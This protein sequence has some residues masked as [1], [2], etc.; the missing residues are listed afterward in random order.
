MTNGHYK[1]TIMNTLKKQKPGQLRAIFILNLLLVIICF[2]FYYFASSKGNVGGVPAKTILY[3]AI[4]YTVLFGG[5]VV[6]IKKFSLMG[7]R[8]VNILVVLVS[9]PS[10]AVIGIVIGL[11][12]FGLSFHKKVKMYFN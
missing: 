2:T 3:T 8:A 10:V 1:F 4:S 12:S 5:L 11:I 7:L 9:A 6:S